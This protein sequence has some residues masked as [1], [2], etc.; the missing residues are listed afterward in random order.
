M[1]E[2]PPAPQDTPHRDL[3]HFDPDLPG[4]PRIPCF[5]IFDEAARKA[6]HIGRPLGL[7]GVSYEWSEDNSKE[8]EK[9]WIIKGETLDDLAKKI[10][11]PED[12]LKDT[13]NRWNEC[14]KVG[15]DIDFGRPSETMFAPIESPPYYAM[16]SWPI[17]VNTQGGPEHNAKQQVLHISGKPIPRLY[18]VGELGSLFGHIYELGGN[19]GECVSS[20]LIAAENA[21]GEKRLMNR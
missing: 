21:C 20:G 11:V 19:L 3:S 16:E 7:K 15:Q 9:G 4:F 8:I 18:A 12:H 6:R 1:N 5:L 2:Y 17:L 10:R 14:V 13:V